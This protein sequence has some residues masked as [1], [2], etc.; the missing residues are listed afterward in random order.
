[1]RNSKRSI[2]LAVTMFLIT[3]STG[4]SKNIDVGDWQQT[5]STAGDCV[6]CI[7]TITEETP[8]MIKIKANN[9]WVGY[10]YYIPIKD[11]YHGFFELEKGAPPPSK[12][13]ENMVFRVKLTY[14]MVTLNLE[15]RSTKIT[16]MSTY[17]K[18][19]TPF[20]KFGEE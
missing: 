9:G 1:M 10:A 13:W 18:A 20:P 8:H 17:R 6:K 12:G 2:F 3:V 11:E 5:S 16:F 15:A 14:D 19:G 7:I 4:Y